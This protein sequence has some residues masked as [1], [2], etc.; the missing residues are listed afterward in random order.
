ML[1]QVVLYCCVHVQ[2]IQLQL[3][4]ATDTFK[5]AEVAGGL[6][7][8]PSNGHLLLLIK[9]GLCC[10][11]KHSMHETC[12]S[13]KGWCCDLSFSADGMHTSKPQQT[14]QGK[15]GMHVQD[16]NTHATKHQPL[17]QILPSLATAGV[18]PEGTI[19]A[20][21]GIYASTTAASAVQSWLLQE[22]HLSAHT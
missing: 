5:A 3:V 17:V 16:A 7:A 11:N 10:K 15:Q 8:T 13:S 1:E 6:F 20:L 21:R 14:R 9:T 2:N 18:N 22:A 12:G 4:T 19:A